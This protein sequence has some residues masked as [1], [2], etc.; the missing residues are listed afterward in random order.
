[1]Q[2]GL[3]AAGP[4]RYT[5]S[6]CGYSSVVERQLPKLN[7]AGSNPATRFR[8]S[9][10]MGGFFSY[11]TG[12]C[13]AT[14][15]R[16]NL[17]T[18]P[19]GLARLE[20]RIER[21]I[22]GN[23]ARLFAGHLQPRRVAAQLV[24]AMEDG[25]IERGKHA[26]PLAPDRYL[27]SL[28]TDDY[29]AIL[30]A[31]PDLATALA[32]HIVVMARE[33]GFHL[34]RMPEVKLEADG[35]LPPRSVTVTA[36]HSAENLPTPLMGHDENPDEIGIPPVN[37]HLLVEGGARA[38]PLTEPVIN[39]GR[40]L[41]NTVVIDDPR[42]SRRHAQLRLRHGRYVL[43]DLGSTRGTT[44][45]GQKADEWLLKPGDVISLG[46]VPVVY[47]EDEPGRKPLKPGDTVK[48]PPV[49]G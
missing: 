7:V 21:L 14:Y 12:L 4:C 31:H 49:E 28:S 15:L 5:L 36:A 3:D 10:W 8:P 34:A 9:T 17:T 39:I 13:P 6:G 42:V 24:R 25:L 32:S 26:K 35:S 47:T 20:E 41:D 18:M 27:V 22:E 48:L 43:Y 37:A 1:M 30:K 45:N 23:F 33:A 46:G 38:I 2:L 19:R 29:Q 40:R 16:Y 44:V 11:P